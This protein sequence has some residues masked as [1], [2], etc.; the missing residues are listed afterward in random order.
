MIRLFERH[1]KRRSFTLDGLWKFR[2]VPERKGFDEK[3][4]ECFPEDF[5]EVFVP[6]CW[7]NE[8][9]LYEYEGTAWYSKTFSV[10]KENVKIVFHGVTGFADVYLDGKHLG[11]HY[12]S[13][14]PFSFNVTGISEGEHTIVV[15][16]D[17]THNDAD[18]IPLSTV[19]WYHYG[20]IIR[21]VEINELENVWI[22]NCKIYYT[23][24]DDLKSARLNMKVRLKSAD[25]V[26][27]SDTLRI[28]INDS[29]IYEADVEIIGE[30]EITV[31]NL[32]LND[33]KLWDTENPYLYYVR[34]ETE[35][36]DLTERIGF[37]KIE[38]KNKV[39]YL[40][41]K[42]IYLKGV[43]RHED[44][45]DWGF[46]FPVKLMKKDINIIKNL[47]CNAIRGSHYPNSE[48]FL[49]YMDQE[50]LLFWEEIP[51]WGFPESVLKNPLVKERGLKMLEE[52]IE[53]DYHHPCIIIWG[54]HNEI[55]TH[56]EAGYNITKAFAEKVRSMDNSRLI[57]YASY[58]PMDDV[59]FT[60]VDIIS[61]NQYFGWY[62]GEIETWA[63]FLEDFKSRLKGQGLEDK[64]IIVSEFGAAALYGEDTFECIKWSENYQEKLLNHTLKLFHDDPDIIG[65]YIWQYCDIRTA[66]EVGLTRARGFNNKGL[67]NEYRKPKLA[68]WSVK[69]IFKKQ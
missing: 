62:Y 9:G 25:G 3:W 51:M 39:L 6:S 67:V 43:N 19:D 17:N 7:N 40:N 69:K 26:K 63:G 14:T 47:G 41:K 22:E 60:L 34:F 35:E 68:Y 8:L 31:E 49:D 55:A 24:D 23:L 4:F 12:G 1:K 27:R 53:R 20:G 50:G 21:S 28:Y 64:P 42:K 13:F 52:M 16:V 2:T 37:R 58:H 30:S 29:I 48:A 46:A 38:I 65:C 44:H 45:P 15:C 11:S 33:V 57:T 61:I 32:E 66:K 36:D 10:N 54:L 18:T 56:T 5:T 59:C